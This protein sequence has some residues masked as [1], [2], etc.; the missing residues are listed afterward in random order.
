MKLREYRCGT[1]LEIKQVKPMSNGVYAPPRGWKGRAEGWICQD[2]WKKRYYMTT[3]VLPVTG[4]EG[5]DGLEGADKTELWNKLRDELRAAW[6]ASTRYCNRLVQEL[7]LSE[8]LPAANAEKLAEFKVPQ[9]LFKRLSPDFAGLPSG[10]TAELC[11]VVTR[12]YMKARREV[13]QYGG[14]RLN[15]YRFPQPYCCRA[16]SWKL[17]LPAEGAPV[18]EVALGGRPRKR[19]PW[20]LRLRGGPE[21]R[22][23][24]GQLEQMLREGERSSLKLTGQAV[25]GNTHRNGMTLAK[26]GSFGGEEVRVMA[27]ITMWLPKSAARETS[28]RL[29][30]RTLPNSFLA[31]RKVGERGNGWTVHGDQVVRWTAAQ[32]R[33]MN[34]MAD[35]RKA[36]T[37][38]G[39]DR[40]ARRRE[41][42][43]GKHAARIKTFAQ[44]TAAQLAGYARR[45]RVAEVVYDDECHDFLPSFPYYEFWERTRQKLAVEGIELVSLSE[46]RAKK[47]G[48]SLLP[49]ADL[50]ELAKI[51]EDMRHDETDIDERD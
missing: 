27:K 1:C 34:R 8:Q 41:A 19:P 49:A 6:L 7:F 12:K 37:R 46:Q 25:N 4:P 2:C 24:R 22:R 15:T 14:S 11:Q 10:C 13:W 16:V 39:K 20:R 36:E 9:G 35:D 28:G 44:Q 45:R 33:R 51:L 32:R 40:Q 31:A 23:Q 50:K 42:W 21:F 29:V 43:S 17:E 26:P 5:V 30:V 47:K 18:I 38:R 48:K 3:V